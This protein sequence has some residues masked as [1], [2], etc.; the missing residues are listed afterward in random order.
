MV[1]AQSLADGPRLAYLREGDI[2]L[3]PAD[4]GEPVRLTT[5]GRAWD[6][7]LAPTGDA[8]A[9]VLAPATGDTRAELWLLDMITGESA[10]LAADEAPWGAPAWAPQGDRL[11]W[12][13]GDHLLVVDRAGRVTLLD[14]ALGLR[15]MARP[16]PAWS[17]DGETV[18]APQVMGEEL[19][20]WAFPRQESARQVTPLDPA[21]E[22]VLA[23]SPADGRLALWQPGALWLLPE[24]EAGSSRH[25]ALPVA[26]GSGGA[27]DVAWSADGQRLALLGASGDLWLGDERA[28]QPFEDGAPRGLLRLV[29]LGAE[30]LAV[31]E[32]D[33]QPR[34]ETLWRVTLAG[35][36]WQRLSPPPRTALAGEALAGMSAASAER[37]YDWY[38]YQ[39]EWDS[40]AMASANCGPTSVAMAIQFARDN[41]WVRI[42]DIRAQ[43]GGSSWTYPAQIASALD[44][45]GVAQRGLRSMAEIQ[46][47]LAQGHIVLVHLWMYYFSP[48]E[49]YLVPYSN[50]NARA[51]R[52]YSYSQSHWAVLKGIS[53]DGAWAI[54]HD[55]NVWEGNGV[56]WYAD[57]SPKGRDR[58][59]RYSEMA[60][61]IAAY[62]Y[63]AIEVLG[64]ASEPTPA[65]TSGPAA[66]ATPRPSPTPTN[67]EG[68]LWHMVRRGDTLLAL[69]RRY[70]VPVAAIAAAN[71]VTNPDRI[72]IGQ[73]LW[74]PG[75]GAPVVTATP[76][77]SPT[78]TATLPSTAAPTATATPTATAVATSTSVIPSPTATMP[79]GATPTPI[80]GI[81]HIVTYGDT[82]ARLAAQYRVPMQAILD[83]NGLG[84]GSVIRIGQRLW[85]PLGPTPTPIPGAGVWYIVQPGESLLTIAARYGITWQA[86]AQA[87]GLTN[88]TVIYPG[89]RLRIP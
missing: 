59:Y 76:S 75:K 16:R 3:A 15:A 41:T 30:G 10:L 78:R 39:G 53:D 12:L 2:W 25:T 35:A 66:T 19:G 50:A 52:F 8:L 6:P 81:W 24:A 80:A 11:A 48:G 65:P 7:T 56:F 64:P 46:A 37:S 88:P 69:A 79:P 18:F 42:S 71:G 31:W 38:R 89:Q 29:W 14:D 13:A 47:A 1:A 72:Y 84:G 73:Q 58:R 17:L 51:G 87:N 20:L 44:H 68:G 40:G 55:P 63:Q 70:G 74:I 5:Q 4:G 27:R 82:L 54:V 57:R 28:L 67:A 85:I 45:W 34:D 33:P 83:A 60:A 62:G 86:I 43:M 9:Y 26:L 23:V 77:P 22:V 32:R 49:D 36:L 21:A 61:S